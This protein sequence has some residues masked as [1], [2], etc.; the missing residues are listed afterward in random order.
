M[1]YSILYS[2]IIAATVIGLAAC[3]SGGSDVAGIGGS[4]ITSTGTITGFGSI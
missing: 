3:S 2:S 1:K 4:G